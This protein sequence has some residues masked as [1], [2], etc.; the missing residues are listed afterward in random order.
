M[1]LA[2]LRPAKPGEGQALYDITAAAIRGL[3]A[4]HYSAAQIEGWMEGR[5]AAQ[6]EAV[7]AK[8]NVLV[9]AGLNGFIET[10]P[11][12]ILRLFVRPAAAGQGLGQRLLQAGLALAGPGEIHLNAT[13]NAAGFYEK[14]GFRALERALYTHENGMAVEIVKMARP[15]TPPPAPQTPP[16]ASRKNAAP[17]G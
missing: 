12:E 17:P 9:D 2:E 13:L 4:G 5:D 14:Q 6:Y 16:A 15:A 10:A 1:A 3:A 7:I 11:G 8:G